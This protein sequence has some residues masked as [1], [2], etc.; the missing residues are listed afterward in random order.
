MLKCMNV[1][2][3]KVLKSEGYYLQLVFI[4]LFLILYYLKHIFIWS[5]KNSHRISY[6]FSQGL[7]IHHVRNISLNCIYRT[8][9]DTLIENL[10]SMKITDVSNLMYQYFCFID[11]LLPSVYTYLNYHVTEMNSMDKK[12]ERNILFYV[13]L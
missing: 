12:T 2:F 4:S 5:I 3:F 1:K 9:F 7:R 13:V 11:T 6:P 8:R 10:M